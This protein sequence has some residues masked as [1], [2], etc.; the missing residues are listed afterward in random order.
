MASK[1]YKP[2]HM[3]HEVPHMN[4]HNYTGGGYNQTCTF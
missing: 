3:L 1:I 4:T 2:V